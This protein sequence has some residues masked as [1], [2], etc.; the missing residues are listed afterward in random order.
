MKNSLLFSMVVLVTAVMCA[1]AVSTP[2]RVT[3]Q[4]YPCGIGIILM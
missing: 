4:V 2:S 3:S 1:L